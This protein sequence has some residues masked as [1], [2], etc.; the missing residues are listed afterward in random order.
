MAEIG[1]L[2]ERRI[3]LLTDPALSQLPAFL[4]P[5]PGLNSGFMLPQIA[6]AALASENA[7]AAL[8][9]GTSEA[10]APATNALAAPEEEELLLLDD[11]YASK[12]TPEARV[13]LKARHQMFEEVKGE[14]LARPEDAAELLRA[15]LAA[16]LETA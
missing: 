11:V 13:R 12:L 14:V 8:A 9:A 1:S 7:P 10:R 6:A 16:D 2:C 3:A 4:S 5:E 15:W